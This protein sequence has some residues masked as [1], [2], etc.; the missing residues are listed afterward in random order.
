MITAARGE[1]GASTSL[2]NS[3]RARAA[4]SRTNRLAR[5]KRSLASSTTMR[6][7]EIAN[8]LNAPANSG[9][10]NNSR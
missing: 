10:R 3:P 1:A 5:A 2:A 9:R 7:K 4:V 6:P 8:A